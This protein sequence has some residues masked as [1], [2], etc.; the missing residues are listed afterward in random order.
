MFRWRAA[1][2]NGL[3]FVKN[4]LIRWGT[5]GKGT[6]SKNPYSTL[7]IWASGVNKSKC[8]RCNFVSRTK[9]VLMRDNPKRLPDAVR[10]YNFTKLESWGLGFDIYRLIQSITNIHHEV[11]PDNNVLT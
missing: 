7:K 3:N 2:L 6:S 4:N 11:A 1:S 8:S 10:N 9:Y 5:I